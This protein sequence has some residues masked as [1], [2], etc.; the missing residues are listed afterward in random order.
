MNFHHISKQKL[1]TTSHVIFE[2]S[3]CIYSLKVLIY[4]GMVSRLTL[5]CWS[6]P[7]SYPEMNRKLLDFACY[8]MDQSFT[9]IS[10]LVI[11]TALM[12]MKDTFTNIQKSCHQHQYSLIRIRKNTSINI[13]WNH[14]LK[15]SVKAFFIVYSVLYSYT[16]FYIWNIL[17]IWFSLIIV[18]SKHIVQAHHSSVLVQTH[19]SQLQ[20]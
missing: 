17:Y 14:K 12:L 2:Y 8:Q 19:R 10:S 11:W 4:N 6:Y 3:R 20:N 1:K 13:L 15:V 9:S 5:F 7:R 16:I 18:E